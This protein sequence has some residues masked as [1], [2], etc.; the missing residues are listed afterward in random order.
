MKNIK[1]IFHTFFILFVVCSLLSC[2]TN[3]P[4]KNNSNQTEIEEIIPSGPIN[5]ETIDF[6]PDESN[7]KLLGRSLFEYDV[8]VMAYSST[9][10]EFNI[11]AKRLDVTIIG[12][13]AANMKTDNGSAARV[14][15]FVNGERKLDEMILQQTQ[16]YTVFDETEVVEGEVRILKVSEATSSLAGISKITVDKDGSICPTAA[17]DLKIEFIGDSITC[18]YGV[19]DLNKEHHFRTSTED[20]TKSYAYKTASKLNADYSMVSISGWGIIS[21][22]SGDGSKQANSQLPRYYDRMAFAWGRKIEGIDPVAIKWDFSLFVP[23]VVVV[24]LGTND[25]SY[26]K[27]DAKKIAEYRDAY[28]EFIKDIRKKNPEAYIICSLGIMGQD[29][30]DAVD[31]AVSEYKVETGDSRVCSLK[32]NNQI[33]SDGIAADWHP[34]EKTHAKAANLLSAKIQEI[35]K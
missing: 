19:D 28:V 8:L 30:F 34:S 25:A 11:K 1:H 12:D 27:G 16:T 14:V 13:S 10:A 33:M 26:T 3:E 24:N 17:R 4:S 20:N 9:G 6:I 7:V 32:F 31:S 2:V 15:V 22:Y 35:L 23:D 18:G 5:K 29:L 21:G